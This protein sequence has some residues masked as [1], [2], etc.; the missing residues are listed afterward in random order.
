MHPFLFQLGPFPIHTYGVMIAAGFL[1]ALLVLK[2]LAP[3]DGINVENAIDLAFL[4][5][6]SGLTGARLL[7]IITRFGDFAADP[8]SVFRV[9]E[10]GFVFYG[11]PIAAIPV[12]FW[13]ARKKKLN[14]WKMG[15][16]SAPGLT[17]GH[18]FG[19]LGCFSAG[20]CYGK[21]TDS[22]FGVKFYSMLVDPALRGVPLHPTQLYEAFSLLVLFVGLLFVQKTK[23]FD[24][25]T[26]LI[27]LMAYPLIR[28]LIEVYRG[29]EI[30]G[31]VIGGVVSTS[32]FISLGV[33]A[34][35]GAILYRRLRQM[36]PVTEAQ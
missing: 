1:S 33:F 4:C 12:L 19:R 3:A 32:Q 36:H 34:L 14:V 30:R 17:I 22:P 16:V 20:C 5:L 11:G 10:G 9:W 15:D 7:Y 13:F 27:Y 28:S 24:G 26:M 35:A 6:I 2:K 21:P 18:F 8:A 29:D 25:Q 23:K 31:F